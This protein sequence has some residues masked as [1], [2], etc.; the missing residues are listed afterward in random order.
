MN[1]SATPGLPTVK[2]ASFTSDCIESNDLVRAGIAKPEIR[3]VMEYTNQRSLTALIASGNVNPYGIN[4]M[5]R[6]KITNLE[7]SNAKPIGST[8]WQFP[9]MGKLDKPAIVLSQIG[10]TSADGRFQLL[11]KDRTVLYDGMNYIFNGNAFQARMEGNPQGSDSAGWVCTFKSLGNI[12][13][14]YAT[15]VARQAGTKTIMPAYSSYSEG[16]RKGHSYSSTPNILINWTTT[17]RKTVEITGDAASQVLWYTFT[18]KNGNTEKGWMYEAIQQNQAIMIKEDEMQKLFG[19]SNMK[20]ADGTIKMLPEI[21]PTTGYG[22]T[23]GDGITEQIAG[24]LTIEGSSADGNW[25][26]DDLLEGMTQLEQYSDKITGCKWALITGTRGFANFQNCAKQLGIEVN[27]R[28]I[29]N[30]TDNGALGGALVDVGYNYASI[31][32][33]GNQMICIKHTLF[34]D[35]Q[36]WT[37]LGQDGNSLMSS[38]GIL[39]DIGSQQ[40][41]N[42]EIFYKSANGVNR[43]DVK[44]YINGLTGD[45]G[46]SVSEEDFN[47][48]AMLKQELI[49]LYKTKTCALVRKAF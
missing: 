26:L 48:F 21:D 27:T 39:L 9:V 38:F 29:Q 43:K 20:N 31:N 32:F 23:T 33:A 4:N 2:Q 8:S 40:K 19:I 14:N 36:M 28:F 18:D 34:D 42:M 1:P 35:Q 25:N 5:G 10:T 11:M 6:S 17:Q 7:G 30:V 3:M 41:P 24:G 22:L 37:E 46:T 16:S 15:H 13:F 47:K 49:V 45:A 44:A 12:M